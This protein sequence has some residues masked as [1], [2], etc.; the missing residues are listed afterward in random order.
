MLGIG[1]RCCRE[2]QEDRGCLVST[3]EVVG[4]YM[5]RDA[6]GR[7][8]RLPGEGVVKSLEDPGQRVDTD[9]TLL[10]CSVIIKTHERLMTY[11]QA[12]LRQPNPYLPSDALC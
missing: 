5:R 7:L 1:G 8:S 2:R 12:T 3:G 6:R 4:R 10:A 11:G 9:C